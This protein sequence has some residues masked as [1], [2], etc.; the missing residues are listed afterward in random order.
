VAPRRDSVWG[1]TQNSIPGVTDCVKSCGIRHV[2]GQVTKIGCKENV[3]LQ[4]L[5]TWNF[6]DKGLPGGSGKTTK[7]SN[8][9]ILAVSNKPN[10]NFL[11]ELRRP[12]RKVLELTQKEMT[13][14]P[15][16]TYAPG[17]KLEHEDS[18]FLAGQI[19]EKFFPIDAPGLTMPNPI[20]PKSPIPQTLTTKNPKVDIKS[21]EDYF[22]RPT[23]TLA[24]VF[25]IQTQTDPQGYLVIKTPDK[26]Q[27]RKPHNP[28]TAA[29]HA[30]PKITIGRSLTND[31]P[32]NDPYDDLSNHHLSI[33]KV[34]RRLLT[35]EKTSIFLLQSL[36]TKKLN[37]STVYKLLSRVTQ[38]LECE[39]I[40]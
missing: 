4:Y 31:L 9:G 36:L 20:S 29:S 37:E 21:P 30:R 18:L 35:A 19:P 33:Q 5:E 16:S 2:F 39:K 11:G 27:T 24:T 1:E 17:E 7:T 10:A 8:N 32:F 15:K 40:L 28:L 38:F 14:T 34:A 26:L 23:D 25:R 12:G 22:M 13:T 6:S 3:S